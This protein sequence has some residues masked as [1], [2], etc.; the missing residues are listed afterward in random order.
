MKVRVNIDSLVFNGFDRQD[1]ARFAQGLEEELSR[2]IRENGGVVA[3]SNADVL[4]AGIM[5]LTRSVKP[6]LAGRHTA[7]SVYRRLR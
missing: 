5:R 2:L 7:Y 6:D 4:E 1:A 3:V